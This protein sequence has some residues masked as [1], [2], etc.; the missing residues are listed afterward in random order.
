MWSDHDSIMARSGQASVEILADFSKFAATFQKDLNAALR[1]VTLD[2]SGISNQIEKGVKDGVDA[3]NDELRR[4]GDQVGD[5][6]SIITQQS[7]TTSRRMAASFAAA[8][9]AMSAVGDQMT[10]ALTLPIAA[11]GTATIL[12]AG[13]FEKAMN[14]VKAATEAT[15]PQFAA[16]RQQAI[17]LGSTTAFSASEAADAMNMLATAGFDT[18]EI[19]SALP[20]VLDMAAAGSVSLAEAADI[21]SNILNGYGIETTR[22]GM[23]N[24]VLARTFLSTATSLRDLGETFK[25]VG[26]VAASAGIAF[27]EISAAIGLMGNA[28]IKGSEAGTALR[29]AITRLLKPTN[30]VETT[31]RALGVTVTDSSGKILPLIDIVRQLERSGADTADMMTIFGL[32]AGPGMQALVSQGSGALGELTSQLKN[33]G[34]TA[35][36]VAKTQMEGFN[37]SMDEL[38]SSAEG[39]VIAIGDSGLLGWMTSLVKELTSL[40]MSASRLSPTFLKIATV[41]AF[42]VAAIGPFFA[43]FGRMAVAIGEGILAFKKFGAWIMRIAPWLSALGGPVGLVVAAIIALAVAAV[44]AYNKIDAFRNVVDRAFRNVAAAALWMWQTVIVPA[45]NWIVDRAKKVGAAIVKLW[46]QAQPVFVALGAAVLRVWN[47]AIKP[48][49]IAIADLFKQVG[50]AIAGFWTGTGRPALASLVMWFQKLASAIRSWWAGNGDSVMRS[51]AQVVTWVGGVMTVVFTGIMAVL[52]AV[53]AV[54]TWVIINVT[55]P[56]WK[57]LI[58]IVR[59]VIDVIVALRPV[60]IVI[61]AIIVAAVVVVIT[62]VRALWAVITVVFSAIVIAIRAVITAAM[63]FWSTFGPIF[64]AIGA[65][66]WAVWSGVFSIVFALLKLAFTVVIAIVQLFWAV[67]KL[68]FMAIGAVVMMVWSTVISPILSAIGALFTWLWE[69]AISPALTFIGAGLSLLWGV[70]KTVFNAAVGFI[71][72]AINQIVSAA[73]G[74]AGFVNMI[75]NYFQSVVNA[76]RS[77]IE[78]AISVVRGLPGQ[79]MTAI[80]NLGSLLYTAGQNVINGLINGISSKIGALRAKISDAASA[81]RNALP[82]SPAK[83]GPLSGGGDPTIAGSKIISMIASGMR[84][85]IPRLQ[86]AMFDVASAATTAMT[87]LEAKETGGIASMTGMTSMISP[88]RSTTGAIATAQPANA[89]YLTVNSIDPRTAADSVMAAIA[90]WERTNGSSWRK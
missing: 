64:I 61:G 89:Y 17:D 8:G 25:Y 27:E 74:I 10:M 60:W 37:G 2:M 29:G 36:R 85:E 83:E 39:L 30:E 31:L 80:G 22:I 79:I 5:T 28:G 72:A 47:S 6:Y 4:L 63:W 15:G 52:R 71:R 43:V 86:S 76:V 44:V 21:A 12:S 58:A 18:T 59:T 73:S 40:T 53:A 87:Y 3:A 81:I 20:G 67:I 57:M 46:R 70:I 62:I 84:M 14:R 24:D 11:A 16:L 41:V 88:L 82:F 75:T 55:I 65:L 69:S 13:N 50:T 19:M 32:E 9:R 33:A 90:R 23:V 42:V 35:S 48:A 1:G 54:I 49:F 45:F 68:A 34:G 51:A 26:P 66:V 7:D 38:S 56:A 77:R 78:A